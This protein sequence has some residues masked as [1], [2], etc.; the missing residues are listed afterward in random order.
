MMLIWNNGLRVKWKALGACAGILA[1][2]LFAGEV[3]GQP[4]KVIN[5]NTGWIYADY[6]DPAFQKFENKEVGYVSVSLPHSNIVLDR[7]D[8]FL[9]SHFRF[10]SSYRRHFTLANEYDGK[11]IIVEFESITTVADIYVNER[12]VRQHKGA[13]TSFTV[14]IT[15]YV[16]FGGKPNI[17]AIRVDSR[18]RK[19]VPPEGGIVDYW[20][21]G[22]ITGDVRMIVVDP[23]YI[24][25]TFVSTPDLKSNERVTVKI[26][27]NIINHYPTIKNFTIYGEVL[28]VNNNVIAT[29]ETS[30]IVEARDSI[31][32]D[33]VTNTIKNPA[34][35]DIDN[36]YLHTVKI[37]LKKDN[38]IVDE[39]SVA[40]GFRWFYFE[41]ETGKFVLN[42]RALELFGLNRHATYPWV[43]RSVSNRI[44]AKDADNLKYD[45]GS[46]IVRLSHYT[47][48]TAFLSRCDEIGLLVLE[49]VP[50][51]MYVGG[52]EW[53]DLLKY[54]LKEMIIRDRNHPSIV[55]WGVRVNESYDN[56][57]LYSEMN[58][59][60]R[61]LDPTRPTHGV[62]HVNRSRPSNFLE[63]IFT[64]N[65]SFSPYYSPWLVT[66]ALEW[67]QKAW[68]Y[69]KDEV[70]AEQMWRF[71]QEHNKG[72]ESDSISGVIGWS[73]VDYNTKQ[74]FTIDPIFCSGVYD[75]FRLPKHSAYFYQSQ[76][77]PYKYGAMVYIANYWYEDSPR[78]VWIASNC[79]EVELFLNGRS[80][81]R[82]KPGHFKA[83][84]HPLFRFEHIPYEP[85]ELKAIGYL[86][87]EAKARH[88]V[89][90]PG[91]ASK[92]ILMP[93]F[94]TITA[95]GSDMTPVTIVAVDA[96]NVRV[97][98]ADHVVTISVSGA[99]KFLGGNP[100]R[101]EGGR[102][103][104]YV[105][106]IYDE[107]GSIHCKATANGLLTGHATISSAKMLEEIVP[108]GVYNLPAIIKENDDSGKVTYGGDW[109]AVAEE[110][111]NK[112]EEVPGY[113][114]TY[115]ISD[116]A[117]TVAAYTFEGIQGLFYGF[118]GKDFGIAEIYVDGQ[119]ATMLDLFST[120][121]EYNKL[122]FHTDKLPFGQHTIEIKTSGLKNPA[123]QGI[124]VAIDA[125]AY[126]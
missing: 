109:T 26:V 63:D 87:G 117:G 76:R 105:Q 48:D 16:Q 25:W 77:D 113:K 81:G 18:E 91:K 106:S 124:N 44:Q 4:R 73:Y 52:K 115:H 67:W 78:E 19:E 93:D 95:D 68:P 56:D 121:A 125:F 41:E 30:Y 23:I 71:A 17:L 66:E 21:F 120:N 88:V 101:L 55:S 58:K 34:L 12:F 92:L 60:A 126:K 10:V 98:K 22:G 86:K 8:E 33:Q 29:S 80:Q 111:N 102:A 54:N 116:S 70:L 9:R 99:G 43:G 57:T 45:L 28:D 61:M 15:D 2:L 97:P 42:G 89:S 82:I 3:E 7:H 94:K 27:A 96:N 39:V 32:T 31:R 123:S 69:A 108:G 110:K 100:I 1:L 83:L 74:P 79:D 49:E 112:A 65:Y 90:T 50:G 46:N 40:V 118:T 11:R 36:P 20:L 6:D 122:L 38:D 13:Y 85:G 84:P 37:S 14:D 53:R 103:I 72:F 119:L 107:L 47:Q 5:F 62:R 24:E 114:S 75:I 59:I 51:W 35:W 64:I 104:F